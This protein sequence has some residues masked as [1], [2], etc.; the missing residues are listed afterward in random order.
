M[1]QCNS[2]NELSDIAPSNQEIR[3]LSDKINAAKNENQSRKKSII[4]R[5][6]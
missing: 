5:Q 3:L 1:E 6:N 2:S 4:L